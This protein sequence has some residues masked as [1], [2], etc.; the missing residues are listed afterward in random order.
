MRVRALDKE[1]GDLI[2]SGQ[3]FAYDLECI[4]QTIGTRL[5][6]FLGEYFRNIEDGT[7]WFQSILGKFQSIAVV[8][9]LLRE[10]ITGTAGVVRLLTFDLQY[11]Q[12]TRKLTVSGSVLTTYGALD[13]EEMNG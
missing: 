2:T 3:L 10:R 6:L 8:E 11:D 12:Q 7:P 13:F 1:T 5:R 4:A 9:S